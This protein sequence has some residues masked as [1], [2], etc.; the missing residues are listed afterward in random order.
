MTD[1]LRSALF[2]PATRPDRFAKAAATGADL[3]MID[4]EDA[5][6]PG[7]KAGA[8]QTV[9]DTFAEPR[10]PA[11]PAVAV[12]INATDTVAGLTD[13]LALVEHG[14]A[15]DWLIVPKCEA[16]E[17]LVQLDRVLSAA[18]HATRLIALIE[19]ARGVAALPDI[20]RATPR[21]GALMVGAADLAAD[22]GCAPGAAH[23]ESARLR[24]V[25][26][27]VLSGVAAIDSPFFDIKDSAGLARAAAD[28]AALGFA[29][30]AAIHPAQIEPINR[31]FTPDAAAVDHARRVLEANRAGVG[32]VDGQM[33]D[34]AIARSARRTLTRAGEPL[35]DA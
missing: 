31:A 16:G 24:V 22:L 34:E 28:S 3:L 33:I 10:D 29:G 18:E 15:P 8:R 21:L 35:P 12:R 25:E 9:V 32:V 5:V 13:V 7:D 4:L 26:A 6:A 1:R 20:A 23:L 11:W 19:S 17:T 30:R 2:T 27:G 14:V